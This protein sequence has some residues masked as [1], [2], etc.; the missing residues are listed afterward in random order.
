M[1]HST[2]ASGWN[3]SFE[4]FL[5]VFFFFF[6]IAIAASTESTTPTRQSAPTRS[7]A[8]DTQSCTDSKKPERDFSKHLSKQTGQIVTHRYL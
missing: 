3:F 5:S 1:V 2:S 4:E 7:R 6:I 8:R